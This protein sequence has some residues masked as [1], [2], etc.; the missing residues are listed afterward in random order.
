M[1]NTAQ[2]IINT[3]LRKIG[4]IAPGDSPAAGETADAL[5]DLNGLLDSLNA[6]R[7]YIYKI[8]NATY[9]LTGAASYTIGPAGAFVATRPE[10]IEDANIVDVSD[11]AQPVRTP[12]AILSAAQ[13]AAISVRDTTTPIPEAIYY[14]RANPAGKIYVYG[15]PTA[16]NLLE[17]WTR[18][19]L[20]T[21]ATAA[22]SVSFP[23]G[24]Y[25]LLW[26]EL[27]GR[28]ASDYGREVPASVAKINQDARLRVESANSLTPTMAVDGGL[29]DSGRRA[30]NWLS[31]R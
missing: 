28:V 13:F 7:N 11:P 25:E 2:D 14:D 31:N 17:L 26:S 8:A 16:A 19:L 18:E 22:T 10:S 23:P 15:V 29:P 27:V 1:A 30:W 24:Y 9:Q 12:V 5:L 20:T 21:F 3:A 6:D 4:V